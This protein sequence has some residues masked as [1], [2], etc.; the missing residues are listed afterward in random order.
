LIARPRLA[1]RLTEAL[2]AGAVLLTA[3]AGYGKTLALEEALVTRPRS[4]WVR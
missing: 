4:A 3:G 1:Q 2:D